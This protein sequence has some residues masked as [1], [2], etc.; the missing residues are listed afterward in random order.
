MARK[1]NAT[2]TSKSIAVRE[3]TPRESAF[4]EAY[5]AHLSLESNKRYYAEDVIKIADALRRNAA[6][7]L[8][9]QREPSNYHRAAEQANHALQWML[10]NLG[11]YSL[12]SRAAE[13]EESK[14]WYERATAAWEALSGQTFEHWTAVRSDSDARQ[15]VIERAGTQVEY[16]TSV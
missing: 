10:P 1:S 15:A 9:E 6:R 4:Y 3:Y 8:Q 11:A 16:V 14:R 5:S 2:P 7:L 12:V 13:V